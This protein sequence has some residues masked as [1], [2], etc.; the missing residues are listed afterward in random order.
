MGPVRISRLAY[1]R[2]ERDAVGNVL[3]VEDGAAELDRLCLDAIARYKRP[4]AYYFVDGL[5]KINY[6]K[7]PKTAHAADER[8]CQRNA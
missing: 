3:R 6:G 7:V 8:P 2:R 1:A 5:P 4:R